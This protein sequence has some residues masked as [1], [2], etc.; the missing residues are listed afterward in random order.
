MYIITIGNTQE[1][2]N[3]Y[4][5]HTGHIEFH[6][7]QRH[8]CIEPSNTAVLTCDVAASPAAK[9]TWLR[10]NK[11]ISKADHHYL[12]LYNHSHQVMS[13]VLLIYDITTADAG[14]Y[15]CLASSS[16]VSRGIHTY[17][18]VTQCGMLLS[19]LSYC[20]LQFTL[21]Y[22]IVVCI[23]ITPGE[24]C[25]IDGSFSGNYINGDDTEGD[26]D[27]DDDNNNEGNNRHDNE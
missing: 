16:A 21:L 5:C 4:C 9:I 14:R 6:N 20:M 26:D 19:P 24:C 2:Y 13:S 27:D 10:N 25:Y 12:M 11:K 3:G 8:I 1:T 18:T 7:H 23:V 17:V 22:G 15:T